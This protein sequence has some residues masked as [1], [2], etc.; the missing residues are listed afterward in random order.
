MIRLPQIAVRFVLVVV[1]TFSGLTALSMMFGSQYKT[2]MDQGTS[3]ASF[4]LSVPHAAAVLPLVS[5]HLVP[6]LAT[7]FLYVLVF[8]VVRRSVVAWSRSSVPP[9]S[10]PPLFKLAVSYLD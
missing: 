10:S 6:I 9:W 1:L 5:S 7:A 2:A 4:C 3:C 8:L